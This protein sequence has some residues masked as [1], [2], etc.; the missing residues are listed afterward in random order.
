[1]NNYA[2]NTYDEIKDRLPA[3]TESLFICTGDKIRKINNIR[4]IYADF[5]QSQVRKKEN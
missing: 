4:L 2:A 3:S 1:M 5:R